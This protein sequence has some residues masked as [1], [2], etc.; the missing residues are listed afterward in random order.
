MLRRALEHLIG[1]ERASNS[2]QEVELAVQADL[3]EQ[4]P[5][6]T[7][8]PP[9]SSPPAATAATG[10]AA[11][12]TTATPVSKNDTN[13]TTTNTRSSTAVGDVT[14]GGSAS[15]AAGP[16]PAAAAAPAS[17]GRGGDYRLPDGRL[18]RL[19]GNEQ[20]AHEI[21]VNP[22]FQVHEGGGV[23]VFFC[24][25]GPYV[26]YSYVSFGSRDRWK[27]PTK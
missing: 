7:P 3:R 11:T 21:L 13:N 16:V 6:S 27:L 4:M 1:P 14:E 19:L 2:L 8:P 25:D 9:S 22:D 24:Y 5:P 17:A 23:L 10:V 18:G 12:A 26:P 20:L 15:N